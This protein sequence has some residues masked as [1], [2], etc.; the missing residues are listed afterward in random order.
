MRPS[1]PP[2]GFY[3]YE[4]LD[5]RTETIFYIGKGKGF[6]AWAHERNERTGKELN[7]FKAEILGDL[8]KRGLS[9]LIQV[10]EDG[11]SDFDACRLEPASD[12]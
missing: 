2:A 6:R 7:P 11:L 10:V 1:V 3:V 9:P 4:L 8:R 5:P 12:L